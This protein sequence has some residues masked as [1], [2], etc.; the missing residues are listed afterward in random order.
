MALATVHLAIPVVASLVA[1]TGAL[2]ALMSGAAPVGG[3]PSG[4]AASVVQQADR[5][6]DRQTWPYIDNRCIASGKQREQRP[7]RLVNAPRDSDVSTLGVA[8]TPSVPAMPQPAPQAMFT[9]PPAQ[10]APAA[11]PNLTTR[12]TVLQQPQA[13][14]SAV[15]TPAKRKPRVRSERRHRNDRRWVARSYDV[16]SEAYGGRPVIVVRPLRIDMFR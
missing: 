12:V 11:A 9:A 6:C 5:S 16:P 14:P 1:G 3:T 2:A 15:E 13:A 10:P 8:A 7:V 4:T